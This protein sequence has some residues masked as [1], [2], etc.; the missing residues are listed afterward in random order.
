M[1]RGNR[2]TWQVIGT[3]ESY[4]C[5]RYW[6]GLSLMKE[7]RLSSGSERSD[8]LR[9]F[10][11]CRCQRW[12]LEISRLNKTGS[13]CEVIDVDIRGIWHPDRSC[14]GL[15]GNVLWDWMKIIPKFLYCHQIHTKSAFFSDRLFK[16]FTLE[17]KNKTMFKLDYPTSN[18]YVVF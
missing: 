12:H 8:W 4:G 10:L 6:I 2:A 5:C 14:H 16:G 13:S 18:N 15:T 9:W 1:S 11:L 7:R 3:C 17:L